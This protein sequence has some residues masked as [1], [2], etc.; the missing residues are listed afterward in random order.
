M[1]HFCDKKRFSC[2]L[3]PFLRSEREYFLTRVFI[4]L[5]LYQKKL[6]LMERSW[7]GAESMM[8]KCDTKEFYL[9]KKVF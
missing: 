8:Q 5:I 1:L 2:N 3:C 7:L 4:L 9:V 6:P